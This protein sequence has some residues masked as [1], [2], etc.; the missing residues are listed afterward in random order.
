MVGYHLLGP[1]NYLQHYQFSY[2]E[3]WLIPPSA[4]VRESGSRA[5]QRPIVR[6]RA[7]WTCG[8]TPPLLF[9]LLKIIDT[10]SFQ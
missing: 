3:G 5:S 10:V 6:R 1:K 2:P 8:D 4:A 9:V 7:V